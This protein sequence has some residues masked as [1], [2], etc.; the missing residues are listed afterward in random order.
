[1]SKRIW[2]GISPGATDTRILV[3]DESATLLKARLSCT[4]A[5]PRALQWLLESLALW[6]GAP[7]RAVLSA[8]RSGG[9]CAT[10]LY[11]DWLP[12]FGGPLYAI[13]WQRS[14]RRPRRR[15]DVRGLGDFRDLK[16]LQLFDARRCDR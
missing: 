12:D 8:A 3:N 4:P 6:Q 16:Q 10:H 13:E 2:A 5:H 15:D 9:G 7:V 14:E 1:M 11:R